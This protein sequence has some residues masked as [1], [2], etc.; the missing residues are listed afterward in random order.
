MKI[1]LN[2]N[3][4][5]EMQSLPDEE[6]RKELHAIAKSEFDEEHPNIG[7]RGLLIIMASMVIICA[8]GSQLLGETIK[9]SAMFSG[10]PYPIMI[11]G[12][13]GAWIGALLHF[14]LIFCEMRPYYQRVIEKRL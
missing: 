14:H 6:S 1:Y 10:I 9:S 7:I 11:M 13:F 2:Y 4:L 12:G 5:P 8:A 3:Q